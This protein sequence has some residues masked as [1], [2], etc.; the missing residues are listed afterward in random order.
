MQ[1]EPWIAGYPHLAV[2]SNIIENGQSMGSLGYGEAVWHTDMSYTSRPPRAT[3]LYALEVPEE[4]HDLFARVVGS[5]A[6]DRARRR[7]ARTIAL[8]WAGGAGLLALLTVTLTPK[9]EEGLHMPWWILE[10]AI[11]KNNRVARRHAHAA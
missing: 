11:H 7:R 10:I 8:L 2:M 5:I 9:D 4:G 1:G 3:M 6:D